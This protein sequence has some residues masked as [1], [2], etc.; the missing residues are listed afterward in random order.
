[1][2]ESLIVMSKEFKGG[3]EYELTKNIYNREAFQHEQAREYT[4]ALIENFKEYYRSLGYSEHPSVAMT[5]GADKTVRFIGSHISVLKPYLSENNVPQPGLYIEQPCIRTWNSNKLL[6]DDYQPN[7]GSYFK[8][9]GVL[10]SPDRLSEV[11]KETFDFLEKQ[12][13]I[14]K[15]LIKLRVKSEDKDLLAVCRENFE[16]ENL[17]IDTMPEE[18]YRHK[19][20]MEGIAGRNFN[21][22]LRNVDNEEFFDVGNIIIIEDSNGDVRGIEI[23]LGTSTILKQIYNLEH[24]QDCSPVRGLSEISPEL[25]RRLE[26]AIISSVALYREGLRPIGVRHGKNRAL[27]TYVR[28]LSY[29]RSKEN[30]SLKELS[31]IIS[32]YESDEYSDETQNTAV[33]IIEYLKAFEEELATKDKLTDNEKTILD[34]LLNN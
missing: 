24:V 15:N 6:E 8:S 12:L 22:A 10:A 29:F 21:I 27:R 18:Y 13:G 11:S 25:R 33:I 14:P 30:I 26:D 31:E 2:G 20:G 9:I 28:S 7:W 17:E 34:S 32:D 3:K 4:R 5:S 19:L 16:S 1:M 23:A